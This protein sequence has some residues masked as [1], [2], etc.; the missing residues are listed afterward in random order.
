MHN[1]DA[2]IRVL[3]PLPP[4]GAFLCTVGP[5]GG[6]GVSRPE[7]DQIAILQ[8]VFNGAIGFGLT[9]PQAVAPVMDGAPIPAFPAI[10][11]MMQMGHADRI[12]EPVERAEVITDIAPGVMRAM[13]VGYRA[14][15]MDALLALNFGR[16][17]IN[18]LIPGNPFIAR[19]T[20]ILGVA[21]AIGIEIH[22]F[23]GISQPVGRMHDGFGVLT[24]RRQCRLARWCKFHAPRLNRPGLRCH[25]QQGQSASGG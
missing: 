15:A 1:V 16:D 11:V 21:F 8:A 24:M 6:L 19:N 13:R 14:R 25:R 20:A 4:D 9:D 10:R 22:P 5:A 7:H 23:H 18:R 2:K 3:E 17:D 12:T